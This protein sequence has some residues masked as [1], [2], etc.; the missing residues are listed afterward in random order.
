MKRLALAF[1]E[2]I[3]KFSSVNHV[4]IKKANLSMQ[5]K[6]V[7]ET[8]LLE[9]TFVQF[10]ELVFFKPYGTFFTFVSLLNKVLCMPSLSNVPYVYLW[11]T[12]Y[13]YKI[14]N[15][16]Q[17]TLKDKTESVCSKSEHSNLTEIV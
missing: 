5:R 17:E 14:K 16:K 2:M 9:T 13:L 11:F 15:V 10:T 3:S 4:H 8:L 12:H 6:A 1:L 7:I